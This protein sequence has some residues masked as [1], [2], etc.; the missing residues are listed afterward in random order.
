MKVNIR[1]VASVLC[2]LAFA[3][4]VIVPIAGSTSRALA[5]TGPEG[6]AHPESRMVSDAPDAPFGVPDFVL[7]E[8]SASERSEAAR[9]KHEFASKLELGALR[10]LA[11]NH[12]GRVKP[13]DTL[14]RDTVRAITGRSDYV[15]FVQDGADVKKVKYDPVFTLL[16]LVIDPAYYVDR[17]LIFVNYLPLRGALIDLAIAGD[18]ADAPAQRERWMKLTRVSP[19]MVAAH[20]DEVAN[21]Y[22]SIQ[23]YNEGLGE[24]SR[25]LM[26]WEES[27][28]NF[29]VIPP[30]STDLA[31][32][33]LSEG[34]EAIKAA[35][36]SLGRAWRAYDADGV[37][38]SAAELAG[39]VRALNPASYPSDRMSLEVTHNHAG[40]FN[41]GMW[42]YALAFISLI[43]AFGTGR[44]ALAWGGTALLTAAIGMH[45]FG[46]VT[47]CVLA[48]R[49]AIQNQFESMTG[50]S[51][52]AAL[53]G[54]TLMVARRQW[55]FG[56]ASAGVGFLVLIAASQDVIPGQSIER[57]A[58]ILSTSVLLKYHVTT[59]LTS[60]GLIALGL[61]VSV[62]YLIA[63]YARPRVVAAS[64]TASGG[65]GGMSVAFAGAALD[66]ELSGENA[67]PS[68]TL[69]D[70]DKA[71]LTILQL[72]FWTLGVGI[73]LGA[74]WADHSWGRWWGW[75]P[76]E[77]FALVT[78]IIYIIVIH[79]RF[80]M[81]GPKR[82]LTTAWLSLV[83]F[84][85]MVWC[86]F[87][88]NLMLSGL[89]AYA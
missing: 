53:V 62:M 78:W 17:P 63:H 84:I 88:V 29:L 65:V 71:Q 74:W 55:L 7:K 46:F 51:L 52:F 32:H 59:V 11:V 35:G 41:W 30:G 86:Y 19:R 68:R 56:A 42:L 66:P 83:G 1:Q 75:D 26:L 58:A 16:D 77:T 89:H 82:G 80:T 45:S 27:G 87:G 64:G 12:N 5:Q 44:K 3:A 54:T 85:A 28:R 15:D 72:A 25:A 14:A 6:N 67:G 34:G 40:A 43:L 21:K 39:L 36:E 38:K 18:A 79:L 24:I 50:V 22:D 31:W 61:V 47:R 10:E 49:F 9:R 2:R 13:I 8:Q 73:L 20:A 33:H 23:P 69:S 81:T 4:L 60:Y 57:E 37:N 76:K 70:L 48:E